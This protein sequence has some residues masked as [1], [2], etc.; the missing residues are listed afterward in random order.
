MAGVN[1]VRLITEPEKAAL[2]RGMRKDINN[3][4]KDRTAFI[5]HFLLTFV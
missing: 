3:N 4:D 2:A 1:K 5:M